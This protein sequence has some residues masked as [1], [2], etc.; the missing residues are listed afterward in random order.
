MQ[1][2]LVN[3]RVTGPKFTKFLQW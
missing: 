1:M 2:S 3:S